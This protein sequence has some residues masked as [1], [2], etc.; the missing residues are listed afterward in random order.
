M[1]SNT[2]RR[3]ELVFLLVL[4]SS[5]TDVLKLNAFRNLHSAVYRFINPMDELYRKSLP[6][7]ERKKETAF[8]QRLANSLVPIN[9]ATSA[10]EWKLW[11]VL[12]A[13]ARL[14]A[15]GW[16]PERHP[17]AIEFVQALYNVSQNY[18]LR[19]PPPPSWFEKVA[20][21]PDAVRKQGLFT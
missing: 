6:E 11:F 13:T 17:L 4:L 3:R 1:L 2:R 8:L 10:D 9:W 20:L 7:G 18:S 12:M 16:T 21:L 5:S 15:T 19:K 14:V